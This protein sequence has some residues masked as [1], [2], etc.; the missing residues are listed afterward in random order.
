MLNQ[1]VTGSW[2]LYFCCSCIYTL[3]VL[4]R[5]QRLR[6]KKKIR[7]VTSLKWNNSWRSSYPI[8]TYRPQNATYTWPRK[9]IHYH[10]TI[11]R[12][13]NL[14]VKTGYCHRK[15]IGYDAHNAKWITITILNSHCGKSSETELRINSAYESV[16][17]SLKG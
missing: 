9:C 15:L 8:Q 2:Y 11:W 7:I 13:S 6:G 17:V 3:S 4:A 1:Y 14:F 5:T 10:I 16:S 12:I